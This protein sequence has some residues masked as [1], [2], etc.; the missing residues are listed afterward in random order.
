MVAPVPDLTALVHPAH[1]AVVTSE[2]QNGVIGKDSKL[3]ELAASA[4]EH[5]LAGM[6]RLVQGA[7]AAGVTVVHGVVW[8]RSDGRGMSHNAPL[9]RGVQ[10]LGVTLEPGS[11]EAAIVDEIG[12]EPSDVVVARYHGINPMGATELDGVLRSLG[13]TTV[14]PCGVSVNV[15]ITN[16]AMDCVNRGY[17]VVLARDAVAGVPKAYADSIID[18]TLSLLASLTMTDDVLAAWE[19]ARSDANG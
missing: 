8:T 6:A 15:A 18:T 4:H 14:I 10:K 7:R 2:V 3:A 5:A 17:R 9:F 13:V 11:Y 1:T 12:E 19:T 16:L